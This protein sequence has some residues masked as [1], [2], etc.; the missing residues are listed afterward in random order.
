[1]QIRSL[2][3]F[4]VPRKASSLDKNYKF[5]LHKVLWNVQGLLSAGNFE[6]WSYCVWTHFVG[7]VAKY[8][9]TK[10]EL[11]CLLRISKAIR[12]VNISRWQKLESEE[13]TLRWVIILWGRDST[14]VNTE[15]KKKKKT[16][17]TITYGQIILS[18][19]LL[20]KLS[21]LFTNVRLGFI[22]TN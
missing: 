2:T 10:Q 18:V 14:S 4:F 19:R 9:I 16:N 8:N 1:M 17:H 21:C 7:F 5:H 3:F 13:N 11:M 15:L 22:H 6:K 12:V 20:T